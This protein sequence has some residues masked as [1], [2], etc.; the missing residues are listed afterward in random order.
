MNKRHGTMY[1]FRFFSRILDQGY[2]L[3]IPAGDD[4]PVDCVVQNGAGKLFKVQIKGTGR[5]ETKKRK[6]PR[7]KV[8]AGTG[9]GSKSS[10]DCTKVDVLCA[11]VCPVD[12]WYIIPCVE[13]NNSL[14]VWF[15]PHSGKTSA[16]TEKFRENWD[17]F[18]KWS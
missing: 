14:S 18:K 11:Y 1:E 8:L 17:L 5:A 3:F 16:H 7:Y 10:I 2:D 12:A 6:D 9:S 15:Y 13:L 4:L